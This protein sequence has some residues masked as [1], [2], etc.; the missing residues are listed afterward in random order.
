MHDNAWMYTSKFMIS[1]F[2][3]SLRLL[4]HGFAWLAHWRP[5]PFRYFFGSERWEQWPWHSP[6][7]RWCHIP[8]KMGLCKSVLHCGSNWVFLGIIT[9]SLY[10]NLFFYTLDLMIWQSM[11][12][13]R[14]WTDISPRFCSIIKLVHVQTEADA[15]DIFAG[16]KNF[17]DVMEPPILNREETLI[18]CALHSKIP[19]VSIYIYDLVRSLPGTQDTWIIDWHREDERPV[20]RAWRD[21]FTCMR[22]WWIHLIMQVQACVIW[23]IHPMWNLY[24]AWIQNTKLLWKYM[25]TKFVK[26]GQTVP[27]CF[28]GLRM[29]CVSELWHH[30][31]G[32]NRPEPAL[33]GWCAAS[34]FVCGHMA[35]HYLQV[36]AHI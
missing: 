8:L 18:A 34:I 29:R 1:I 7:W 3:W 10:H 35:W 19:K 12:I 22:K 6:Q 5:V 2:K 28:W 15:Q 33:P 21:S 16:I 23:S 30:E 32:A 24:H 17:I 31:G 27:F 20:V 11:P 25:H 13:S 36:D 26:A 4:V 14:T 9:S